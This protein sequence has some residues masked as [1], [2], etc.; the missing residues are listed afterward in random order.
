MK[1]WIKA[2]RLRTLPL[3]LSGIILGYAVAVS[4]YFGNSPNNITVLV[5]ALVVTLCFQVLSNYANDYGDGVKG[6][7]NDQRLGPKRSLQSGEITPLQMKKAILVLAIISFLLSIAL[8]VYSLGTSVLW[9]VALFVL[10]TI[11]SIWAAIKYTV[12]DNAYGY[13]ALGDVF[14]F[15]F[16]GLLSVCGTFYLVHQHWENYILLPAIFVGCY[17]TA[18][19]NLNNMRDI[20]NDK[21]SGKTTIPVRLGLA[22][23][24]IY[25]VIL[26]GLGLSAL[27]TF[28]FSKNMNYSGIISIVVILLTA[29]HLV[30]VLKA[31]HSSPLDPELKFVALTTFAV[32]ILVSL[33]IAE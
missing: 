16:F 25:H 20:K 13:K 9:V 18:V 15:L 5:L 2:A 3:S 6:T 12:G 21:N 24:K 33:V 28:V 26:L 1:V 11:A 17:S 23:A 14:V 19:L 31:K 10:L 7:D 4:P 30:K 22:K 8:I 27:L 32:S 29:I